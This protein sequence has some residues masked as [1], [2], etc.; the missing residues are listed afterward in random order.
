[1]RYT[2]LS[3]TY[4]FTY[5]L[6]MTIHSGGYQLSRLSWLKTEYSTFLL[7]KTNQKLSQNISGNYK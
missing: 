4:I 1:M 7:T 6:T 3:F 5:L 2:N